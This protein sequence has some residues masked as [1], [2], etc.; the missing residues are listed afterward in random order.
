[1]SYRPCYAI[2]REA[3]LG[4]REPRIHGQ[5]KFL[6]VT[7]PGRRSRTNAPVA[8]P[9]KSHHPPSFLSGISP[10]WLN[11]L[12]HH[13]N[14]FL[15]PCLPVGRRFPGPTSLPGGFLGQ[16]GAQS[17]PVHLLCPL[18]VADLRPGHD[19]TRLVREKYKLCTEALASCN[20]GLTLSLSSHSCCC[21]ASLQASM[22]AASFASGSLTLSKA[23]RPGVGQNPE[24]PVQCTPLSPPSPQHG[25]HS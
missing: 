9:R 24:R 10:S 20:P 21:A 17:G 25:R 2:A 13:A 11:D 8:K 14:S 18:L 19:V 16:P 22:A 6:R 7:C 1:M 3:C 15:C 4:A 5:L 23:C 12:Q